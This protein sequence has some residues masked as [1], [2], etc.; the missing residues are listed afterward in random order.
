[1]WWQIKATRPLGVV[2]M[3]FSAAVAVALTIGMYRVLTS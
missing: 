1:M 2:T 3:L